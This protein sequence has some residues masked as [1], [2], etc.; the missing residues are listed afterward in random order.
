[1][2]QFSATETMPTAPKKI[3]P[4][5]PRNR[6]IEL[7]PAEIEAL[8]SGMVY[9]ENNRDLAEIKNAIICGD[10]FDVLSRLPAARFDLLFADP[11]YNLTK[12]FGTESFRGRSSDDYEGWLDSWLKL[13]AP[14]LKP[15]ATSKAT[16][17]RLKL[18]TRS[19]GG[20]CGH[21]RGCRP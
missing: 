7:Q 2:V 15:T 5:A 3:K 20:S 18:S 8:R 4:R 10:A 1:M 19:T 13:C 14:L 16:H 9:A 6:T 21:R 17:S 12:K 11:P